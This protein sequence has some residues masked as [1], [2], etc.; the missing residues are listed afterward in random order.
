MF[1]RYSRASNKLA[2]PRRCQGISKE[3]SKINV[4]MKMMISMAMVQPVLYAVVQSPV[5]LWVSSSWGSSMPRSTSSGIWVMIGIIVLMPGAGA[6]QVV[7][8]FIC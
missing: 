5:K 3:L 8:N 6:D 2:K 7:I 1:S 4:I